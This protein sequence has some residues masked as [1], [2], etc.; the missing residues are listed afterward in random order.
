MSQEIKI[1][2]SEV[3]QSISQMQ[4]ATQSFSSPSIKTISEPCNLEVVNQL[5]DLNAELKLLAESYKSLLLNNE[6]ATLRSV[7]TF[8][9]T[10][11]VAAGFMKK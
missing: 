11:E 3:E 2:W 9:Q 8:V 1:R 4:T 7:E 10:D 6:S 5:N